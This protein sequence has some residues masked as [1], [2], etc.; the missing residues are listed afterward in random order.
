MFIVVV[1]VIV[2]IVTIT[3]TARDSVPAAARPS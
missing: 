3:V 1:V 2:T